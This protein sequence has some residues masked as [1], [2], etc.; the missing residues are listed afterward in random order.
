MTADELWTHPDFLAACRLWQ[1]EGR[2]CL[3]FAD[4]LLERGF[5]KYATAWSWAAMEE[6]RPTCHPEMFNDFRYGGFMPKKR[7]EDHRTPYWFSSCR[8]NPLM[9]HELPYMTTKTHNEFESFPAAIRWFLERWA[10]VYGTSSP[11]REAVG[12]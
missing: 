9:R 4:W 8:G 2:A 11:A 1:D 10:A 6:D 3:P 5:D 7:L 12:A